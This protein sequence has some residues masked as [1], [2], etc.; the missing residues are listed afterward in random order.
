MIYILGN[1]KYRKIIF[2][3]PIIAVDSIYNTDFV[4]WYLTDTVRS[5][6]VPYVFV[7]LWCMFSHTLL[8]CPFTIAQHSVAHSVTSLLQSHSYCLSAQETNFFEQR[9]SEYSHVN[10]T[11][12]GEIFDL[13]CAY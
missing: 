4:V 11:N 2:H 12:D 10:K 6:Y 8:C 9:V 13:D 7:H 3:T 5:P 1:I